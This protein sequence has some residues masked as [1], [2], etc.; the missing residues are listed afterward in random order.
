MNGIC[1]YLSSKLYLLSSN[2]FNG[3]MHE[4][5]NYPPR[6]LPLQKKRKA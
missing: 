2:D 5:M 1:N 3:M 4:L 6:P